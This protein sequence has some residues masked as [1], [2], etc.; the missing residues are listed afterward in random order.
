MFSGIRIN[1]GLQDACH[2][3]FAAIAG[4]KRARS[5]SGP[6]VG[7]QPALI[8]EPSERVIAKCGCASGHENSEKRRYDTVTETGIF[9]NRSGNGYYER[10]N[11]Q[12]DIYQYDGQGLHA[13]LVDHGPARQ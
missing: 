12:D 3:G 9:D 2:S 6:V 1:M 11:N 13:H 4:H 7:P 5:E 8:V 10:R